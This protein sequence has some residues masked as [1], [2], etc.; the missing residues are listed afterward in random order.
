VGLS[1]SNFDQRVV[2]RAIDR[3]PQNDA[4]VRVAAKAG[5]VEEGVL[6]AYVQQRGTIRDVSVWSRVTQ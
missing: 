2:V 4:S 6:R 5:F 3:T 1:A